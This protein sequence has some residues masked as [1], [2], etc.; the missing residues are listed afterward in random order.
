MKKLLASLLVLAMCSPAM[1]LTLSTSGAGTDTLT[2]SYDLAEGEVLRGLA[3]TVTASGG[4]GYV[5][6]SSAFG[7]TGATQF[8]TFMDFA[9]DVDNALSYTVG[10][11]HPFALVTPDVVNNQ[12]EADFP[13]SSFA[14]S[15][16][17]LDE[18]GD[19][20]KGEGITTSGTLTVKFMGTTP[21]DVAVALDTFRGGAVGD[22]IVITDSMTVQTLSFLPP[23]C[24]PTTNP[25]YAQWVAVGKPLSWCN[26]RQC[27]GD[28]NGATE[29]IGKGSFWVGP[30][31]LAILVS[32]YA[33]AY[34][35]PV[36][37]PWISADFS[38]SAETIGK[39]SFRVGTQDLNILVAN[40]AKATVA[41]TCND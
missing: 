20:I 35:D 30:A 24:I 5:A 38:R 18:D 32:G 4:D 26:P 40:Y 12:Y 37:N 17:Y 23:E 16:G 36:T 22:G 29:V 39:G 8:N 21:T 1:A 27:N 11:G 6:D 3:L 31:D 15:L 34:S 2:I 9:A 7:Q 19:E 41:D 10:A 13:T 14:L 33:K 25:S 28:A